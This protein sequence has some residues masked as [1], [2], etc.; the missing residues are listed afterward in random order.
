[1]RR[2]KVQ[3]NAVLEQDDSGDNLADYESVDL[4]ANIAIRKSQN[5]LLDTGASSHVTG[6]KTTLSSFQPTVS[7]SGVSTVNGTRLVVVGKGTLHVDANKEIKPILYVLGL[8][9]S[10]LSVGKLTDSGHFVLFTTAH[11]F[12]I[13]ETNL[14]N[15]LLEV[16][17]LLTSWTSVH[18]RSL[19]YVLCTIV[20]VVTYCHDQQ[21]STRVSVSLG[22]SRLGIY[23]LS[24]F[25]PH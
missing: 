12:V 14:S 9:K 19:L 13:N 11:Y 18:S 4:E 25:S 16:V 6:D 8:T 10:L 2:V 23:S 17:L 24:G 22:L 7:R 21:L 5:Y 20:V 15:I 1:M 3:A